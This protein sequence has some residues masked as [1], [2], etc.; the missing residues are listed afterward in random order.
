MKK[1]EYKTY[2]EFTNELLN[3]K[4]DS[5]IIYEGFTDNLIT[6]VAGDLELKLNYGKSNT[7]SVVARKYGAHIV[8]IPKVPLDSDYRYKTI[9][10]NSKQFAE[11]WTYLKYKAEDDLEIIKNISTDELKLMWM[12][13]AR[14]TERI[15]DVSSL[16]KSVKN[17]T[18]ALSTSLE[19]EETIFYKLIENQWTLKKDKIIEGQDYWESLIAYLDKGVYEDWE[20][21]KKD[22]KDTLYIHLGNGYCLPI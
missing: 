4:Y 9:I 8:W 12:I 17:N 21:F 13:G 3:L 19:H 5:Q 14:G 11:L 6:S 10:F 16:I 2:G 1:L 7:S 15:E 22:N 20:V 18:I